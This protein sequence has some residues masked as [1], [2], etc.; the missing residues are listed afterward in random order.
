L[1]KYKIEPNLIAVLQRLLAMY[2][3]EWIKQGILMTV[4]L[5]PSTI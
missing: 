2:R 4:D 5:D 1:I 3:A